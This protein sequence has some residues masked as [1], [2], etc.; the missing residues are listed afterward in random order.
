M[1]GRTAGGYN[2]SVD[3]REQLAGAL[4]RDLGVAVGPES[5]ALVLALH[6]L[7][8][9][10]GLGEVFSIEE[11][12]ASAGLSPLV[13]LAALPVCE[14]AGLLRRHAVHADV[15]LTLEQEGRSQVML[16]KYSGK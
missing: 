10:Q 14:Q 16:L 2:G 9:Q 7:E 15:F 1:W 6:Q 5:A 4:S 8:K 13:A 12:A 3:L 11:V